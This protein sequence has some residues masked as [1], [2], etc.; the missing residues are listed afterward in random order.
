MFH[1]GVKITAVAVIDCLA[2]YRN[3][4]RFSRGRV[5]PNGQAKQQ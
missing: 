1:K 4:I 2:K 5:E 3:Q